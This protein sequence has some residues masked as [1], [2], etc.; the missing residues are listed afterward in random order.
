MA[1]ISNRQ[2][3]RFAIQ[4]TGAGDL[5]YLPSAQNGPGSEISKGLLSARGQHLENVGRNTT[6][7][8]EPKTGAGRPWHVILPSAGKNK[9]ASA[10]CTGLKTGNHT[11]GSI[12]HNVSIMDSQ[13]K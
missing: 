12:G 9:S 6:V 5:P 3:C 1:A 2:R 13:T 8:T 4:I 10:G 11:H 7:T